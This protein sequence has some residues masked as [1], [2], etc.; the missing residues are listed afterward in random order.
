MLEF[1]WI[2]LN[3]L[4]YTLH[5]SHFIPLPNV[6]AGTYTTSSLSTKSTTTSDPPNICKVKPQQLQT[7]SLPSASHFSQLNCK[8]SLFTQQQSPLVSVSQSAAAQI[9][10]FYMD[11]SH[12]SVIQHEQLAPH[13]LGWETRLPTRFS[14][15]TSVQ[16]IPALTYAP[17][18][19]ALLSGCQT[20]CFPSSGII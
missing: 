1:T 13:I 9:P 8:P 18:P 14:Q 20:C 16:L 3:L 7:S 19:P 11:P 6:G 4:K 12:Y 10:A 2:C 17:L 15:P 5:F